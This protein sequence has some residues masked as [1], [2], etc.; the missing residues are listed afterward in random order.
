[1]SVGRLAVGGRVTA[2][3]TS[4]NRDV[5]MNLGAPV[6]ETHDGCGTQCC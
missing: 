2:L 5:M 3:E 4:T 1:M 6:I